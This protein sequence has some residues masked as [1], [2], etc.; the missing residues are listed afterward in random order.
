[1]RTKA[2]GHLGSH[3][4]IHEWYG[5]EPYHGEFYKIKKDFGGILI[6]T[7][8]R[9]PDPEGER[10]HALTLFGATELLFVNSVARFLQAIYRCEYSSNE[11]GDF[12]CVMQLTPTDG[13]DSPRTY[14]FYKIRGNVG[15]E[16]ARN[17]KLAELNHYCGM[18]EGFNLTDFLFDLPG[19]S[20]RQW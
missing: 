16:F 7:E 18:P 12:N 11:D 19:R 10:V 2:R 13:N 1:M 20:H 9:E 17:G 14:W 15:W 6:L 4:G 8:T 3:Y 5:R